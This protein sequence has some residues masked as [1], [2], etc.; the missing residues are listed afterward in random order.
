M[1]DHN[2]PFPDHVKRLAQEQGRSPTKVVEDAHRED[3]RGTSSDLFKRVRRGELPLRRT[4]IESIAAELKVPPWT[5]KEWRPLA[6]RDAVDLQ[7]GRVDN[8]LKNL[9]AIEN[10][11]SGE[12]IAEMISSAIEPAGA[13]PPAPG[14]ELGRRIAGPRTSDGSP[15]HKQRRR[16]GGSPSGNGA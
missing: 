9:A 7:P 4:L 16:A 15:Q 1:P 2:E 11:A 3:V 12:E 14:G 13:R 10:G 6:V 8:A 5:F